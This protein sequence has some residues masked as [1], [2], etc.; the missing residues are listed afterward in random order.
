MMQM[1]KS[2]RWRNLV[3]ALALALPL[4]VGACRSRTAD[5]GGQPRTINLQQCN[6]PNL[7]PRVQCG[8]LQVFEDRARGAGRTI[9]LRVALIPPD[10]ADSLPDPVFVLVGGPGQSAVDNAASYTRL[11]DP[12][13]RQR[14]LVFVDQRGTGG[15]NPLPCDLY[16]TQPSGV[17]GDFLPLD[18]VRACRADLENRADLRFYTSELAAADLDDVRRALG[19]RQ[20]NLEAASYGTRVALI[21][22]RRHGG[23][24]RS[25]VLRSVS[26]PWARQ[27]LHF[28][29]DAQASF[30]SLAAA[31]RAESACRSAFPRLE[32]ELDSVLSRLERRPATV[33]L[34]G[35]DSG[36]PARRIQLGRGAFAE[37]VRFL[38]YAPELSSVLPLLIHQAYRGNFLPFAEL[39]EEVGQQ[40]ARLSNNGMYLA[41]TCT[42]DVSRITAAEAAMRWEET[43]LRDYRVQQQL[44]AC[45]LWPK[46]QL[47]EDFAAPITSDAPVLIFSSTIDPITPPR[48]AAEAAR[49]LTHSSH[50][51]VPNGGHSPSTPCVMG[52]EAQFIQ[53]ASA[54]ALDSTCLRETR[55]PPFAL[56][57]P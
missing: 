52:I 46:G 10:Q 3:G 36:A 39:A 50:L 19:Y 12:L 13:R 1:T 42:E 57:L 15:S 6:L 43:F 49:N 17:L 31:C 8:E 35:P 18:A 24:V 51:L 16:S 53:A 21:Y 41:V 4:T 37:K 11:L 23:Q 38:L 40:I 22:L 56:E 33:E 28:A 29:E 25:A 26:P 45:G 2:E 27:P 47:S 55:R 48:G 32:A 5:T 14:A 7:E 34:S 54:A 9:G 20:I 30:D 44:A